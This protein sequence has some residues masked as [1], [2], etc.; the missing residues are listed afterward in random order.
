ML[1]GSWPLG[2]RRA[3]ESGKIGISAGRSFAVSYRRLPAITATQAVPVRSVHSPINLGEKQRRQALPSLHRSRVLGAPGLE[4][5]DELLARRGVVPGPVAPD[6]LQ[7]LVGCAGAVAGSIERQRQIEAGLIVTRI[8][9][10]AFGEIAGLA[11]LFRL[12]RK[13]QSGLGAP[14]CGVLLLLG[15]EPAKKTARLRQ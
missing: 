3:P 14:N 5:L 6:D 10:D 4:E 2:S 12:R 11:E 9:L 13:L 7:E 1:R 15:G 8:G